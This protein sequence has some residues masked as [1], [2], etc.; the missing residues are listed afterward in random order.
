MLRLPALL[1]PPGIL[2]NGYGCLGRH[3]SSW[4]N[5]RTRPGCG[6]IAIHIKCLFIISGR[7]R[8]RYRA[9]QQ[10]VVQAHRPAPV[11][12]ASQRAQDG[13]FDAQPRLTAFAVRERRLRGVAQ[14]RPEPDALRLA[15]P[16]LR[17]QADGSGQL[18]SVAGG[19]QCFPYSVGEVGA[20]LVVP[21]PV[22]QAAHHD[23]GQMVGS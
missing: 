17:Q 7:F 11:R 2:F 20:V 13:Q 8:C 22:D 4:W 23:L 12:Q 5:G 15:G 19:Q 21:V 9:A 3:G 1:G 14:R 6:G 10:L 18:G 16:G